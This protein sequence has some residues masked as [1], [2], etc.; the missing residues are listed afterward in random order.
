MDAM[1][2]GRM[3]FIADPSGAVFGLWQPN[4]HMG[5]AWVNDN[6]GLCW[7]ELTTSNVDACGSFYSKLFN[8]SPKAQDMGK[9]VYTV[10]ND[11]AEMRAG[12]MAM[13]AGAPKGMPSAWTIYFGTDDCDKRTAQAK[14]LGANVLVQPEN[15]PNV[16]RFSMM[17]DPQG[18]MFALLQP[19]RQ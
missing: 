13:P 1:E 5:A 19:A 7:A 2:A 15:I 12:M 11:G 17:L 3:A 10:F 9:M 6:G 14:S 8:W 16:G 18:A 4:K